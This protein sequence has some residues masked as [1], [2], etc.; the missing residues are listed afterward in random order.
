M[1]DATS[2]PVSPSPVEGEPLITVTTD[3][4]Y[5]VEGGLPL[6]RTAIT[7]TEHG[8]PVEW[9]EGPEF[10][11]L[12]TYEL[13]RCGQSSRKPYCDRTHERIGFDGTE[14]ADRGPSEARRAVF[15]GDGLTLTD[16]VTLCSSAG[17]CTNRFTN[18]WRMVEEA[19]DPEVRTRIAEMVSRC[20]SGRLQYSLNDREPIEPELTQS[21]GVEPDGPYRVMGRVL[22]VS[23]DGTEWEVRNRVTLCRCGASSN[24]PFC[25]GTH[26]RIGFR[27]PALPR[28]GRSPTSP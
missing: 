25:D 10:E 4:P 3:G 6:V 18:V 14:T 24:K 16:D 19:S 28:S 8:E 26:K 23:D 15:D 13:C 1:P 12:E 5:R 11:R 21:V 22:I 17:F 7:Q 9:A 27:D 20:P 2:E